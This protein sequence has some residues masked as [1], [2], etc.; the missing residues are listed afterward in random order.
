MGSS[1]CLILLCL[2][3]SVEEQ[4]ICWI[5]SCT[6]F[7]LDLTLRHRQELC[8]SQIPWLS[9]M[10]VLFTQQ[11]LYLETHQY[12]LNQIYVNYTL[13]ILIQAAYN[14]DTYIAGL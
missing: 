7:G 9:T 8:T 10:P 2:S 14:E 3:S 1:S 12:D 13:C 4:I 6:K 5:Q 11:S